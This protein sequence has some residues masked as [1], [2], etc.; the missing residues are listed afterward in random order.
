MPGGGGDDGRLELHIQTPG[1]FDL[2][3]SV[4]RPGARRGQRHGSGSV[5]QLESGALFDD[6]TDDDGVPAQRRDRRRNQVHRVGRGAA[7]LDAAAALDARQAVSRR[8]KQDLSLEG[9]V[10]HRRRP[11]GYETTPAPRW[12]PGPRST[13]AAPSDGRCAPRR[14]RGPSPAGQRRRQVSFAD[15]QQIRVGHPRSALAR[16]FVAA[17]TRGLR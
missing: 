3:A 15:H 13:I 1:H 8:D 14:R 6:H 2:P 4:R 16:P 17:G 11:V 9:I 5:A 12:R 7:C 10:I